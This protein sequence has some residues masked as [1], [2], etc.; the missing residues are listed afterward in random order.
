MKNT[1]IIFVLFLVAGS[2]QL[3]AQESLRGIIQEYQSDE[4]MSQV[5]VKN[6]NTQQAVRSKEDGSF[7]I[8]ASKDEV[9]TFYYP[10]YRI[11]SLVVLSFEVKRIYMSPIDDPN[12]LD[13]VNI[14]SLTNNRLASEME[15]LRQNGQVA[16]TVTGGGIGISP[17]RIFGGGAKKARRQYRLL[18]EEANN[19]KIDTRFTT[20]LVQSLTPLDG[21]ELELFMINYR[22]K[23]S[24]LNTANEETL[25]LYV[26]DSYKE[27][28][29]MS[30]A[31]KEKIKLKSS[32]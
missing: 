7:E 31:Q 16:N 4:R 15:R 17:S 2:F 3:Q 1:L 11:D 13:E 8:S 5:E 14:T 21:E 10:G 6:L 29:A 22:P 23:I 18:E 28:Q 19:R 27:F 25:K 30:D 26:A 24:F 12:M 32:N 9:L 20:A